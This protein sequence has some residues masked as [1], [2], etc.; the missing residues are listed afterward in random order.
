[1][2]WQKICV[3][4]CLHWISYFFSKKLHSSLLSLSWLFVHHEA[5]F[6][7]SGGKPMKE[8]ESWRDG[9]V[10]EIFFRKR[11]NSG[12]STDLQGGLQGS[13][14]HYILKGGADEMWCPKNWMN[15][16][17]SRWFLCKILPR[18]YNIS[19]SKDLECTD[20]SICKNL[21]FYPW[22]AHCPFL[23]VICLFSICNLCKTQTNPLKLCLKVYQD[24]KM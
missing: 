17:L 22:L 1:M 19:G 18:N 23:E 21:Y 16:S 15:T 4:S 3:S 20:F 8:R 2:F 5:S 11:W 13:T 7:K 24:K 6:K 14:Y 12:L 9:M 10:A